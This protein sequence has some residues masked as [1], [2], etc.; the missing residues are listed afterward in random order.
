MGYQTHKGMISQEDSCRLT[1]LAKAAIKAQLDS[2][3]LDVEQSLKERFR[4]RQGVFVTLKINGELRG[5]IGFIEPVYELWDAVSRAA[6]LAAFEDNRFPQLS[7]EEY[8]PLEIELSILTVPELVKA[9]NS[10]DYLRQIEIGKHGLIAENSGYKGLLLP[11]VFVEWNANA[12][13]ALEMTC[14][15]AGLAAD[16]WKSKETK[17]FRFECQIVNEEKSKPS[18]CSK[19]S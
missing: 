3:R 14:E 10:S 15:K 5:C 17:I 7:S 12:K 13:T 18:F 11:Q 16:A 19:K 4:Q 2:S 8:E 6:V 9:K 1:A